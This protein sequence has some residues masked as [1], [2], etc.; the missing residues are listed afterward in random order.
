MRTFHLP[1][2]DEMHEALRA[3]AAAAR[4]PATEILRDAL[5]TWLDL[6]RRRRLADDI[7]AYA[8]AQSGTALDLDRDL[9]AA[10]V[11]H[12]LAQENS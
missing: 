10:G 7:E 1:M 11:E 12:L 4:R 3:E 9:E 5:T 6:Q 8:E 2:S